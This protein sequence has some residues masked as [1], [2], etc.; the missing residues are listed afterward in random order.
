M[1]T[2]Y[3]IVSE[4]MKISYTCLLSGEKSTRLDFHMFAPDGGSRA[5]HEVR[6]QSALA[7]PCL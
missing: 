5:A 1:S 4:V 6:G 2:G 7:R 3:I